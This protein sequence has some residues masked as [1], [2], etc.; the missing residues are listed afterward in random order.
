M[1]K[2]KIIGSAP[3]LLVNDVIASAKYYRDKVGFNY[4]FFG[5]EPLEFCILYRDGFHLMLKQVEDEK[6]IVPHHK[7]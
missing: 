7:D 5:G 4:D 2:S 6:F 3:I 1:P